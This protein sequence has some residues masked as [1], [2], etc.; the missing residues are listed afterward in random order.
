MERD[1]LQLPRVDQST[2]D[3]EVMATASY[4][5]IQLNIEY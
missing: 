2:L 3:N 1:A 5:H 4:R